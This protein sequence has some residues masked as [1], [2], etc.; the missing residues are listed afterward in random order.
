MALTDEGRRRW[1]VGFAIA[2]VVVGAGWWFARVQR[3]AEPT[4]SVARAEPEPELPSASNDGLAAPPQ[5]AD[6]PTA[7]E[8]PPLP[9]D[10]DDLAPRAPAGGPDAVLLAWLCP[11]RPLDSITARAAL[12]AVRSPDEAARLAPRLTAHPGVLGLAR[13]AAQQRRIPTTAEATVL[14][15]PARAVVSPIDDRVLDHVQLAHTIIAT[16]GVA[17]GDRTRARAYLAKV[18]LQAT[19]QLGVGPGR[20]LSPFARLVG[21][22]ALHYGLGFARAYWRNR[23]RGLAPLFAEVEDRLLDLVSALEHAPYHGDAARLAVALEDAR[24]Y[25]LAEDARARIARRHDGEAPPLDLVPEAAV[26]DRLLHRGFVDRAID[27]ALRSARDPDGPGLS[28]VE[29]RLIDDLA[30]AERGEYQRRVQQR[31]ARAR[32]ADPAP[33]EEGPGLLAALH[34]PAWSTAAT[35]ADEATEWIERAP[36]DGFARAYCLG[37]AL[38]LLRDRPDAVVELIDRASD[39]NGTGPSPDALRWMLAEFDALDDGARSRQRRRTALHRDDDEAARR[40]RF[41]TAVR[42]ADRL[43]KGAGVRDQTG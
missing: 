36:D 21:G 39:H 26:T 6:A 15:D 35:V 34:T 41:A 23:V 11:Q 14:P 9:R 31:F 29:Q 40:R 33:P 25:V 24:R 42:E 28:A 2:T 18:Y 20:P 4:P 38:L 10:C 13:L 17:P 8:P 3:S 5:P 1:T 30:R 7:T 12:L 27:R 22:R 32:R 37:R 43:P 19:Q 16:A